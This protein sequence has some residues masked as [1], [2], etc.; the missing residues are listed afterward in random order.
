MSFLQDLN[1]QAHNGV[2]M[3]FATLNMSNM[4]LFQLQTQRP[5]VTPRDG[6][7][8]SSPVPVKGFVLVLLCAGEKGGA[9]GGDRGELGAGAAGVRC[10]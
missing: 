9:D 5:V 10:C 4:N 2:L 6:D 8:Q 3:L 1:R 7:G